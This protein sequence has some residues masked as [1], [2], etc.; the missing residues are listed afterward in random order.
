MTYT[1]SLPLAAL[2]FAAG[3]SAHKAAPGTLT[4]AV[5]AR[6]AI[7]QESLAEEPGHDTALSDE[8]GRRA[9]HYSQE[10][11][12]LLARKPAPAR[13]HIA[14][15]EGVPKLGKWMYAPDG[16]IAD[17]LGAVY[18]GK[19]LYEPINIIICD[20]YSKTPEEAGARLL[21]A[22][23]KAGFPN[24]FGHSSGYQAFVD[25]AWVGQ[26][27][28]MKRYSFAD[29]PFEEANNHGRIFG[30]VRHDG[31]YWFVAAF[32]R[33][34]VDMLD[35]VK[36]RFASFNAAR[37]ALAWSL[38][39]ATE[40]KVKGFLPLENALLNN[41]DAVTGDHDGIGVFLQAVR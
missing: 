23:N 39:S 35:K 25:S 18:N 16:K 24:R 10:P 26:F 19:K 2:L 34:T 21:A 1:R 33:E 40:Y 38:N 3:C 7:S 28:L 5:Y 29:K 31:Q 41:P 30:P 27:Q 37:D 15:P 4:P 6:P 8:D 22:L 20:P 17:W 12:A 32:S 13:R 14:D 11:L 36:H 9:V